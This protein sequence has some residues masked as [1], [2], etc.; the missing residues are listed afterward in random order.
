MEE[1]GLGFKSLADVNRALMAKLWWKFRTSV[2]TLWGTYMENKYCK[3]LHPI[4]TN[5][6]SGSHVWKG[7][8]STRE[9]LE[10][11][12]L[13]QLK[14]GN[15]SFWYDNWIR[16]GALYYTEGEDAQEDDVEIQK[17]HQ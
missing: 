16:F 11:Y 2:G 12:I 8:V 7:M 4:F 5:S 14:A 15:S 9:E 17:T 10:P 6:I 13:W 1:G 3:K